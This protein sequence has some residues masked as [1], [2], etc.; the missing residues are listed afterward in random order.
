MLSRTST[1]LQQSAPSKSTNTI[2]QPSNLTII[3]LQI[4]ASELGRIQIVLGGWGFKYLRYPLAQRRENPG[5]FEIYCLL[6]WFFTLHKKLQKKREKQRMGKGERGQRLVEKLKTLAKNGEGINSKRSS[7]K[8]R[9][10][11]RRYDRKGVQ[12][13]RR[14]RIETQMEGRNMTSKPLILAIYWVLSHKNIRNLKRWRNGVTNSVKKI[15]LLIE[16][17][18]TVN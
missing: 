15:T 2:P 16:S 5:A 12:M 11:L 8:S 1:S 18:Y 7:G 3:S 9:P 4:S 10:A 6:F 14:I 17:C 13:R